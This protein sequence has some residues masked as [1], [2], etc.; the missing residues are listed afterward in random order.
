MKELFSP[1]NPTLRLVRGFA[2]G[3]A[4]FS[5]G[6]ASGGGFGSSW[7]ESKS[8]AY[9]Y[10][11]WGEKME[12]QSSNLIEFTNLADTIEEMADQG[13]LAGKEIFLFTGNST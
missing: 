13:S 1:E 7:E 8:I 5:F 2:I 4:T 12:G 9:C 10:G 6:D 3:S 11:T